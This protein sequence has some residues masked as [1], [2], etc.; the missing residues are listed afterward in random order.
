ML[1]GALY[2]FQHGVQTTERMRQLRETEGCS[3]PSW[4]LIDAESVFSAISVSPI[5]TPAER[6]LLIQLQWL[7]ELFGR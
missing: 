3:L 5:K 2:E 6:S 4:L 1:N 7:R